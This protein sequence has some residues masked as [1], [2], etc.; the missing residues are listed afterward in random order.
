MRVMVF[1]DIHLDAV[2][3]GNERR[4]EVLRFLTEAWLVAETNKVEMVIFAGDAH[5]PGG[6][7]DPLYSADL[8]RM[9]SQYAMAPWR[10]LFVAVAGNHDVVDTSELFLGS[11]I[12]TLT[13]LRAAATLLDSDRAGR[14]HIFDRPFTRKVSDQWAV[15]GL[16]YLSRAHSEMHTIWDEHALLHA[17]RYIDAGVGLIVVAHRV[18][19]GATLSSETA[20]MAKGQDQLFPVNQVKQLAPALVINGHYHARQVVV[21][22]DLSIVIP[23]SPLSFTFGEA[24]EVSKGVLLV[25]LP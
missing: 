5:D 22:E 8:L 19:P 3:A 21:T 9:M 17:G 15:L 11:P 14:L 1:S 2:T 10:P 7:F 12:T 20:E 13:P 6:L 25:E 16:P 23:G 18:V 4:T 24:E